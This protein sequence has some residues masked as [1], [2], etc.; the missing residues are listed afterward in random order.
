MWVR[1]T[2]ARVVCALQMSVYRNHTT[3]FV[4]IN[5]VFLAALLP[6]FFYLL[7]IL[8]AEEAANEFLIG[9][10]EGAQKDNTSIKNN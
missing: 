2:L 6:K 8:L 5:P 1:L 3:M 7:H 10:N 9:K 4:R